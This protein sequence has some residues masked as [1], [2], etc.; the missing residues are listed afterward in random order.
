MADA[1]DSGTG[2]APEVAPHDDFDL[3]LT[4][5]TDGGPGSPGGGPGGPS[6]DPAPEGEGGSTLPQDLAQALQREGLRPVPGETPEAAYGRLTYHLT[7]KNAEYGRN[8][9]RQRD[10][11]AAQVAE[12]REA[13]G[14]ILRDHYARERQ[15]QFELQ[16]AQIPDREMDPQGY[17]I[18][19][20]EE[21]LRRDEARR[22]EEYQRS[23]EAQQLQSAQ[24]IQ[25]QRDA[26]DQAGFSKVAEGLGLVPGSEPDPD[27]QHA[28][29]I[30]SLGAVE[31]AKHLY[32]SATPEEIHEF[33]GLSF[34]W[35]IRQAETVGV[36]IRQA[37]KENF[38][39]M[40]DQL[41][42]RGLV[43]RAG[44]QG[45]QPQQQQ[46]AQGA[47]PQ[48]PQQGQPPARPAAQ[49]QQTTAQRM[50]AEAAAAARRGP[51]AVPAAT[52]PSGLPG[53]F[54]DP[55][56]FNTD[57]DYVEAALAGILGDETQRTQ[58]HRKDR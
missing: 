40:I 2:G 7:R 5:A 15:Q 53:Q 51:S 48:Q 49:S 1:P 50:Q 21:V 30:Y 41:V 12:L 3:P 14:P 23:T 54:P 16:A 44:G 55:A 19:L 10:T 9:A 25:A 36:D 42:Q 33:V 22:L 24:W 26:L 52:R 34:Q 17:Q 58:A 38:R 4:S 46:P 29:D 6:A 43:V 37:M 39:Q 27:F 56:A 20:Q 13:L 35:D 8:L 18:W 47:R 28:Y 11:H 32:P 45:Q 31:T 57:E